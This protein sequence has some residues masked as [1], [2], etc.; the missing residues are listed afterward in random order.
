MTLATIGIDRY[1]AICRAPVRK[2]TCQKTAQYIT[3]IWLFACFTV[4]PGGIGHILTAIHG[5]HVCGSPGR[6]FDDNAHT[7]KSVMLAVVALWIVPS[8]CIMFNRFYGIVKYVREHSSHL[9]LVLG[10]PSAKR[11]VKLTRICVVMMTTY[12]SLWVAFAI[13]VILRNKFSSISVHCAYLWTY[14]LAYCSFAVV[15]IQ[16]MILDRR[17]LILAY[18]KCM[19]KSQSRVSAKDGSSQIDTFRKDFSTVHPQPN[20]RKEQRTVHHIPIQEKNKGSNVVVP[21]N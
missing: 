4:V 6:A 8:L 3:L 13:M 9:R 7:G 12:L 20:K 14:S 11:E 19:R 10:T 18:R 16:Y 15:P 2:I 5:K 1:D 21:I 17:F